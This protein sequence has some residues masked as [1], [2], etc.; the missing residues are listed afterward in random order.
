MLS[1]ST[2]MTVLY[3]INHL[4]LWHYC[5]KEVQMNPR[6]TKRK[7]GRRSKSCGILSTVTSLPTF[8][9]VMMPSSF[10]TPLQKPQIWQGKTDQYLIPVPATT[11]KTSSMYSELLMVPCLLCFQY[12]TRDNT[13]ELGQHERPPFQITCL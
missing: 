11:H 2:Y 10:A 3:T 5:C 4:F 7:I 1:S 6:R 13:E 8:R 9:K 12:S